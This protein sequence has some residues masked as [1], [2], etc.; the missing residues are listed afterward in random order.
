M[1]KVLTGA[2]AEQ[3]IATHPNS[4]YYNN[5]TGQYVNQ[6]TAS[7]NQGGNWFTN[8]LK[9][10]SKP[11]R[12]IPA[13]VQE[14]ALTGK[15]LVNTAK[16]DYANV[17]KINGGTL[18]NGTDYFGLTKEESKAL[19]EDPLQAGIKAGAG[20]ASYGINGGQGATAGARILDA[21][22]A[23]ALSSALGGFSQS[24]SGNELEDTLKGAGLGFVL[25]GAT[26]GAAE[27][28]KKGVGAIKSKTTSNKIK[29]AAEDLNKYADNAE[30]S[31]YKKNI[32]STPTKRLGK[33]EL[34]KDVYNLEN[35]SGLS[36]AKDGEE[37][38]SNMQSIIDEYGTHAD[39]LA[40]EFTKEGKT[41]N[42]NKILSKLDGKL[43][44]TNDP[45][46]KNA[47]ASQIDRFKGALENAGV[48][49]NGDISAEALLN[50]K[51]EFGDAISSAWKTNSDNMTTD[52]LK[53]IYT[54]IDETLAKGFESAGSKYADYKA[55]NDILTRAIDGRQWARDSINQTTANIRGFDDQLMD[56]INR[57][58]LSGILGAVTG[59]AAG[60]YL[61]DQGAGAVAGATRGTANLLNN[62]AEN[63]GNTATT[64]AANIPGQTLNQIIP[65]LGSVL[66]QNSANNN[67]SPAE[68]EINDYLQQQGI[69]QETQTSEPSASTV[70]TTNW[71]NSVGLSQNEMVTWRNYLAQSVMDGS[72]SA[73]EANG[74]MKYLGLDETPNEKSLSSN[75]IKA[76]LIL[77]TIDDFEDKYFN[78]S[79]LSRT[80][81]NFGVGLG[82]DAREIN[83]LKSIL[84]DEIGRLQSQGAINKEEEKRFLS[85][86]PTNLDSAEDVRRKIAN[87]RSFAQGYL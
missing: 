87:L 20:V 82:S 28:V 56:S 42:I 77:D 78:S 60:K 5:N 35:T 34:V 36:H 18:G 32:G 55:V 51:R 58:S 75:G 41:M 67:L 9:T 8:M 70:D 62:I 7:S 11:F 31:Q 38:L 61:R 47:I 64:Q 49:S 68:K 24:K 66:A 40:A 14:L 53:G 85:W 19:E 39:D 15:D 86:L 4:T 50:L 25:G 16:G 3:W 6:N 29:K 43:N 21:A 33:G 76:N 46:A 27:G 45:S 83:N 44:S 17:R 72:L 1:A 12:T 57:G 23:G 63:V 10:A 73:T 71:K 69:N 84:S 2:E 81:S 22:K 26:Q 48:S 59:G 13:L 79:G 30:L 65:R 54:S 80:L 37:L 74:L 52:T